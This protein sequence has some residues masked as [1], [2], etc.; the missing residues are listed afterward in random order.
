M[1]QE[2]QVSLVTVDDNVRFHAFAPNKKPIVIDYFSPPDDQEGLSSLELLL[3]SA[4]SCLASAVKLMAARRM[5]KPISSMEVKAVGFRREALP[6]DF[7][8]WQIELRC[9]SS[10]LEQAELESLVRT[11]EELVCPVFAMLRSDNAPEIT[12]TVI[13]EKTK[14]A[15][16]QGDV[17]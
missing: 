13:R 12:A 11:A 5:K 9:V 10:D 7:S 14:S 6:T 15:D 16:V 4:S 3:M 2:L 8:K 17:R 1:K